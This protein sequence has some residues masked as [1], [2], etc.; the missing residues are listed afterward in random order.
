MVD[1]GVP[2]RVGFWNTWLLAPRLWRGGPRIPGGDRFFAPQVEDRAP[3]VGRALAG[4]FDVMALS[5]VFEASEQQAVAD[6]WPEADLIPGPARGRFKTASS[7]LV[8]L[9]DPARAAVAFVARHHYASGGDVRDSDTFATKGALLTS[10]RIDP[11]LPELDVVSTHL[12]AG[13]D[14]FPIPGHDDEERHHR[15]RMAQVDELVAFVRREH[16]PANALLVVGDF[17]VPAHLPGRHGPGTDGTDGRYRDLAARFEPLGLTDLW[18]DLGVGPGHT[19]SFQGE[20]AL[21][22]SPDEPDAVAD[23]PAADPATTPGERIDYLWFSAPTDLQVDVDR[24][25]RWGFPGRGVT[26]GPAGT[27]SDHLAVTTTLTLRRP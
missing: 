20:R 26:G 4:R 6:G 3:L 11:D 10:V 7:G 15:V 13:G 1:A 25:R 5:E 8:T 21:P 9:V 17:N 16:D 12:F 18:A 14:L 19:C 24:P 2:V 27:L 22:A 23:D